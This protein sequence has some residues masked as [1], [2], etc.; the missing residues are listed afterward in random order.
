METQVNWEKVTRGSQDGGQNGA[1]P[2]GQNF[3]VPGALTPW[4]PGITPVQG[5]ASTCLKG[6]IRLRRSRTGAQSSQLP[7]KIRVVRGAAWGQLCRPLG[8]QLQEDSQ[9]E[10]PCSQG[11][12]TGRWAGPRRSPGAMVRRTQP[13]PERLRP[14][15]GRAGARQGEEAPGPAVHMAPLRGLSIHGQ[16]PGRRGGGPR[17]TEEASGLLKDEAMWGPDAG[18][19]AQEVGARFQSQTPGTRRRE[20]SCP[21]THRDTEAADGMA[22]PGH[23]GG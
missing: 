21:V 1:S 23:L 17:F 5:S 8:E 12:G 2:V 20:E 9:G 6:C 14:G 11:R 4:G 13:S 10:G 22:W 18:L 19:R 7:H 15:W 16:D 3:S